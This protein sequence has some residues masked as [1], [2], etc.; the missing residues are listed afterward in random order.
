MS[1][2]NP[3]EPLGIFLVK[4]GPVI[5]ARIHPERVEDA[6]DWIRLT[7]SKVAP[8]TAFSSLSGFL[9]E[10]FER[11]YAR[12]RGLNRIVGICVCIT[13]LLA[14]MGL[15]GLVRSTLERD[16]KQIGVR[17][18]LGASKWRVVAM[19]SG[20]FIFAGLLASVLAWPVAYYVMSRWLQDFSYRIQMTVDVFVYST[21]LALSIVVFIVAGQTFWAARLNPVDALRDE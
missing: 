10:R 4:S 18:V 1:P 16:T 5:L 14:G 12:E 11:W 15:A 13:L 7:W 8:Q 6:V 20:K 9:T 2:Q 17:R 3:V 21:L 19:Y